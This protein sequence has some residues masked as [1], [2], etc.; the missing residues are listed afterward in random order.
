MKFVAPFALLLLFLGGGCREERRA[1]PPPGPEQKSPI[2]GTIVSRDPATNQVTL[3]HEDVKGIMKGMT[4]PFDLKGARV[5]DLPP[6]GSR[7][8][9]ILHEQDGTLWV[10]DLRKE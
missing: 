9:G 2:R 8:V 6:D 10:S 4:M 1:V 7:V 5:A 3:D